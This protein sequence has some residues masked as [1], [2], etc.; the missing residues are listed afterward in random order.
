VIMFETG[1][2]NGW[3]MQE[4]QRAVPYPVAYSLTSDVYKHMPNYTDFTIFKKAGISGFNCAP[5]VGF[6]TYQNKF[7]TPANLNQQTLQHLGSYAVASV[8]HFGDL[9]LT[10]RLSGN[11]VYF[12][13]ARPILVLYSGKWVIPLALLAI[14]LFV[15]VIAVSLR[16]KIITI[17]GMLSGFLF[18]FLI[19][20]INAVVGFADQTVFGHL[21]KFNNRQHTPEDFGRIF[22]V[23]NFWIV[24]LLLLCGLIIAG[25]YH[26]VLKRLPYWD[27]LYGTLLNWAVLTIISSIYLQGA[28]YLFVWPTIMVLVGLILSILAKDHKSSFKLFPLFTLGAATCVLLY[29]PVIYLVFESMTIKQAVAITVLAALPMSI[30]ILLAAMFMQRPEIETSN[31]NNISSLPIR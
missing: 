19:L 8:K 14:L 11:A 12:T 2:G 27:L 3:F 21:Y 25:V 16:M 20:T 1:E 29:T 17:K 28:S 15:I 5:I 6:E 18:S 13:L 9:E 10:D 23:S 24:G 31:L 22:G 7:D 26:L 30:I 4:F